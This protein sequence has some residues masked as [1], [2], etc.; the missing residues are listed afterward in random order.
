MLDNQLFTILIAAIESLEP[1]AGIP[2]VASAAGVPVY[3]SYQPTQQGTPTGPCAFLNIIDHKRYG[4]VGRTDV[5]D[6]GQQKE[7]H[8]ETQ[9]YMTTF[10]MS[11]LST[12]DPSDTA[13]YTAGDIINLMSY[14]M[15]S[16]SMIEILRSNDIGVLRVDS[17]RNPYFVD[18][19]GRFEASPS[20][21]FIITHKQ[22][23]QNEIA[24]LQSTE[25]E[26]IPV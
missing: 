7:I 23:V 17:A 2:N 18:D 1:Q 9:Q 24:V 6:A 3:Q 10:Q 12:Q 21:D 13:Q 19:R 8:T 15:N 4:W 26:I 5:W 11:A 22:I 16:S 20:F 14:I 25:F